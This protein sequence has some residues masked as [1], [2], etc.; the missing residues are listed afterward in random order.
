MPDLLVVPAQPR[1]GGMQKGGGGE[2]TMGRVLCGSIL[3]GGPGGE[4][5]PRQ[6]RWGHELD[7]TLKSWADGV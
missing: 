1:Q 6:R 4:R 5:S 7:T 2:T 3:R